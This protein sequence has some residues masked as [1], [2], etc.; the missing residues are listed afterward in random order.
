MIPRTP[1]I[2]QPKLRKEKLQFTL[3]GEKGFPFV[4]LTVLGLELRTE[5]EIHQKGGELLR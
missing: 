2:T 4:F 1:K 5:D 3:F